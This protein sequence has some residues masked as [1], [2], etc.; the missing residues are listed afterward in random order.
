MGNK[1]Q[2][3]VDEGTRVESS[4]ESVEIRG[5][6]VMKG[7]YKDK[8]QKQLRNYENKRKQKDGK[9]NKLGGC[10]VNSQ[11]FRGPIKQFQKMISLQYRQ[12]GLNYG[13]IDLKGV[14]RGDLR[15][16]GSIAGLVLWPED[17][18]SLHLLLTFKYQVSLLDPLI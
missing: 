12:G 4:Q 10:Q 17:G 18:T 11:A 1:D 13:L 16:I 14:D 2:G 5:N 7:R 9:V 6:D 8:V 15:H 3:S